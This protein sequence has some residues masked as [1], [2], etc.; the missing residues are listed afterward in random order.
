[1]D[2]SDYIIPPQ[3]D[4]EGVT[5]EVPVNRVTIG[6][7][8]LSALLILVDPLSS[9]DQYRMDLYQQ[10]LEFLTNS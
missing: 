5:V 10:T 1:M 2:S 7:D 4:L 8:Q 6:D 9:S 3:Q